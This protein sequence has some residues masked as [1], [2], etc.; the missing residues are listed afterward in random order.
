MPPISRNERC[1]TPALGIATCC[2]ISGDR[3]ADENIALHSMHTI[4]VREHN[5]IATTLAK[6]HPGWGEETT[7]QETRKLDIAEWQQVV[8]NEWLPIVVKLPKYRKYNGKLDARIINA[9]AAAAFR[10]GH[11]LVPNKFSQLNNGYTVKHPAVSLRE[12][13]FNIQ[14]INSRGIEPTIFGL[15]GNQSET[16]DSKFATDLLEN[17]F[18]RPGKKEQ[19]I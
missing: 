19:W 12:A 18:V 6:K 1:G 9:F 10:F 11:S 7:Y 13:F 17:L 3:R 4:W 2:S 14:P 8:F 5:R 16:V 15:V